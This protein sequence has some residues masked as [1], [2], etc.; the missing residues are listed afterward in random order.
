MQIQTTSV[1][2]CKVWYIT[3]C[4]EGIITSKVI[5]EDVLKIL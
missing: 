3:W 2:K 5:I 4:M 1:D